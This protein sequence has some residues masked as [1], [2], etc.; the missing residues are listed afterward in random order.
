MCYAIHFIMEQNRKMINNQIFI[1]Q[2]QK[3]S[4]FESLTPNP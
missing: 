1:P 4:K 3:Q 2:V